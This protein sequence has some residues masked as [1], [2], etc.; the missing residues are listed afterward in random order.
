MEYAWEIFQSLALIATAVTF[1]YA[2][3]RLSEVKQAVDACWNYSEE[4][5]D[6]A[7]NHKDAIDQMRAWIEQNAN[8]GNKA[9]AAVSSSVSRISDLLDQHIEDGSAHTTFSDTP[10]GDDD[11]T[12]INGQKPNTFRDLEGGGREA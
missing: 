10:R 4:L 6:L 7:Q 9:Y 2:G 8:A 12:F 11:D 3:R 5:K 1:Y